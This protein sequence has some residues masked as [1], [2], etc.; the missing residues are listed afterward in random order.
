MMEAAGVPSWLQQPAKLVDPHDTLPVSEAALDERIKKVLLEHFGIC[1]LFPVQKM[2]LECL[3]V[4]SKGDLCVSAATGSGKT[5]AYVLPIIEALRSRRVCR[6]RA[7]IV[8]PGR[9]LA[10]QV[11]TVLLPFAQAVGLSVGVAVGQGSGSSFAT[12]QHQFVGGFGG[13][14]LAGGHSLIDILVATPGRLVDHL[15]R[16][17]NFTLQHLQWLVIDEAD[18]LLDQSFQDW[19]PSLLAALDPHKDTLPRPHPTNPDAVSFRSRYSFFQTRLWL[20]PLR[21]ML[22]SASLTRNP[23]KLYSLHL[24]NPTLLAVSETD[25]SFDNILPATLSERLVVCEEDR[26]P[27]YLI[28]LLHSEAHTRSLCFT[29]SL[30]STE[31]LMRLL[32]LAC[33]EKAIESFSSNTIA[34]ERQA[35]LDRFN[36]DKIDLLV[37]SD[38]AARGLDLQGVQVVINYD[39]PVHPR[40]YLHRVGRTARAG[41]SGMAISLVAEKEA[42]HFKALLGQLQREEPFQKL[43]VSS[44]HLSPFEPAYEGALEKLRQMYSTR[45]D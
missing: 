1:S 26:K 34:A 30:Q 17:R 2:V 32:Q 40:T 29:R 37:C 39:V 33:P 19:L 42:R 20:T 38:A 25:G 22:F 4:E 15:Q 28:Y 12:E 41:K 18:R 3:L 31:R 5:L 11:H 35:V 23:A 24:S 45:R 8:V 14:V 43:K 6:L 7:L 21:K 13:D 10:L 44:T 16:T 9:E 27:L 36:T